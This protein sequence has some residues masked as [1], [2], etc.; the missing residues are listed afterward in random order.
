[1]NRYGVADACA[2]PAGIMSSPVPGTKIRDERQSA[3]WERVR[4]CL[5]LLCTML[6]GPL[7]AREAPHIRLV[8]SFPA[9]SG[10]PNCDSVAQE[11]GRLRLLHWEALDDL[12]V[13][14]STL[15]D[16]V[17]IRIDPHG[18]ILYFDAIRYGVTFMSC[19][20]S[21]PPNPPGCANLATVAVVPSAMQR[22]SAERLRERFLRWSISDANAARLRLACNG[23]MHLS[24]PYN[25]G[26]V[27]TQWMQSHPAV[28]AQ[29]VV[30][31]WGA[32]FIAGY[33]ESTTDSGRTWRLRPVIGYCGDMSPSSGVLR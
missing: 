28:D 10:I 13:L 11:V 1:M 2:T 20:R 18:T 19:V 15:A 32:A 26:H 4:L 3:R 30:C 31:N 23:R 27:V 16:S 6:A 9:S 21:A 24:L 25:R 12:Q 22:R 33:S 14:Q 8:Q 29:K 17:A 5:A 7:H